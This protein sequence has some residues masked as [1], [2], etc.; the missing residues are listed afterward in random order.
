MKRL[1][2]D[3]GQAYH[4]RGQIVNILVRISVSQVSQSA[5]QSSI[6]PVSKRVNPS[7]GQLVIQSGSLSNSPS[8]RQ[9]NNRSVMFHVFIN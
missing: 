2:F 9:Y 8:V 4:S 7:L 6:Q 3:L 1:T 5:S